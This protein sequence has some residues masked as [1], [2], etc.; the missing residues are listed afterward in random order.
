MRTFFEK[1]FLFA[2]LSVCVC[3]SSH[4]QDKMRIVVYGDGITAGSQVRL[5][6]AYYSRLYHKLKDIG[7]DNVDVFNMSVDGQSTSRSVE[8]LDEVLAKQP[9]I[10]VVQLGSSD[11]LRGVN[12]DLIY[13]NLTDIISKLQ[14]HR[15]YVILIGVKAPEG[16]GY[17]YGRQIEAVFERL[18]TF[19]RVP[20][21]RD[22]LE[23][24]V[25]NPDLTLAD[26]FHPNGKGIDLIVERTYLTVDAMLRARWRMLNDQRGYQPPTDEA[27]PP[28]MPSAAARAVP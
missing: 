3:A 18:V 1:F 16:M 27:L 25:G 24:I 21:Y 5:G 26:G 2:A 23:G 28:A 17:T 6:E 4:A 13:R 22:A 9:D 19:F 8:M 11:M 14:Q 10:V 12:T 15:V 7:Y 20:F